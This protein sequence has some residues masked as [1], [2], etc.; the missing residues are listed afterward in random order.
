MIICRMCQ[1]TRQKSIDIN[2]KCVIILSK[3]RDESDQ[4]APD[5]FKKLTPFICSGCPE[6]Y[7]FHISF[8]FSYCFSPYVY[9]MSCGVSERALTS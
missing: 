3:L 5:F 7:D 9:T 8:L 6:A 4:K 2:E 1:T